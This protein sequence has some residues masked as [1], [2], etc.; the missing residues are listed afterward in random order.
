MIWRNRLSNTAA[1]LAAISSTRRC[2]SSLPLPLSNHALESIQYRINACNRPPGNPENFVPFVIDGRKLGSVRT[3]FASELSTRWSNVFNLSDALTISKSIEPTR[4]ARSQAIATPL[5]T[6]RDEGK[7]DGWRDELLS[8]VDSFDEFDDPVLLIERAA[9]PHFG[10]R[11][12]G[13]HMNGYIEGED[14]EVE[15]LWVGRRSLQKQT[16]PGMLDHL[17]AGGQPFGISPYDNMVKECQEEAS[18]P[19]DIAAKVQCGGFV[20]YSYA[21]DN[22][23]QIKQDTLFC[24][25]LAVPRDFIPTPCDGEVQDFRLFSIEEVI[26][27]FAKDHQDPFKPNC[28][29]VIID[30]LVRKNILTAG[31]RGYEKIVKS[32]RQ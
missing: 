14:G 3:S 20:S 15:S 30:F 10:C 27:H 7:I 21:K 2:V 13:V 31:M 22:D 17:V 8:V 1:A 9:M 11:S 18:I 23:H 19:V 26:E 28:C 16:S 25:D 6:L 32:L 24:Y 5:A 4:S 12:Y 29:L